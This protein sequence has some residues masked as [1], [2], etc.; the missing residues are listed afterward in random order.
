MTQSCDVLVVGGGPAGAATATHLARRGY[1]VVLADKARF[2][3]DKVCGEA[4][5]PEAWTALREIDADHRVRDLAPWPLQGMRLRA[6]DGTTFSGRYAD[7]AGFAVRRLSL[8]AA[9][10]EGARA[11]GVEVFESTRVTA[12]W[13]DGSPASLQHDGGGEG[14]KMAARVVV[15]ADGR[16]SG[17]TSRL[18]LLRPTPNLRKFAVRGHWEQVSGLDELG[19][20]HVGGEGYCGVAPLS[21]SSANIAFVLDVAEMPAAGG[22]LEDFYRATLR[23]WP[24]IE[25]RL[26]HARLMA[27]PQATG[28][29]A[30]EARRLVSGN[31]ILVGDAAGFYDPFTG[32]GVTLALRSARLAAAAID[33]HLRC[34]RSLTAYETRR[35]AATK[36]KFRFNRLLQQVVARPALANVIARKLARRPDA[37]DTLVGIAGDF[38]PASAAFRLRSLFDLLR[39]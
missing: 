16:G 29:L 38:V 28:P 20:M 15:A 2:P 7:R 5:S 13:G 21:A 6:P 1:H 12:A 35:W 18:G 4:I 11:S 37:A 23:R 26:A 9:L 10:L 19:E 31:V 39:A 14:I 33:E 22:R 3:R 36:D 24:D 32:E 17:I 27:P 30:V 8:D 25:R 34:R